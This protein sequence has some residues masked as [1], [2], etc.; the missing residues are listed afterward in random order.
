MSEISSV[1][2]NSG[3]LSEVFEP[4]NDCT[5]EPLELL[6]KAQ[7]L[8]GK[9]V[10][11]PKQREELKEIVNKL[12]KFVP[13]QI[14]DDDMIN[15]FRNFCFRDIRAAVETFSCWER[16]SIEIK[17]DAWIF[18]IPQCLEI[19]QSFPGLSL[20]EPIQKALEAANGKEVDLVEELKRDLGY[21]PEIKK[22]LWPLLQMSLFE[23]EC[24]NLDSIEKMLKIVDKH[25]GM[26]EDVDDRLDVYTECA[27]IRAKVCLMRKN[28]NEFDHQISLLESSISKYTDEDRSEDVEEDMKE[29]L[30]RSEE[31]FSFSQQSLQMKMV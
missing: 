21:N 31:V 24:Q 2:V 13:D 10:L 23:I 19:K 7:A 8:I 22:V 29:L 12:T 20:L 26:I 3:V 1:D 11:E 5:I 9:I 6:T 4:T 28:K 16:C 17:G 27:M 25:F 15:L 18:S 30:Q 14:K